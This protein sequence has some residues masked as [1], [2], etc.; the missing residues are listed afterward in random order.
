MTTALAVLSAILSGLIVFVLL[1]LKRMQQVAKIKLDQEL[2]RVRE[3]YEAEAVRI[4]TESHALLEQRRAEL[5]TE[6][7]K[8]KDSIMVAEAALKRG[9]ADLE[10]E[11]ENIREHYEA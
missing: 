3:H 6:A 8:G 7:R 9:K 1:R 4:Q 11:K 10:A 5:E 2:G